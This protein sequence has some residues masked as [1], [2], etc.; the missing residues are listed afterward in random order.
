VA[1]SI[2]TNAQ[3]R[4]WRQ[5]GSLA[6]A[7]V[8]AGWAVILAVILSHRVFVTNDSLSNYIHVWYVADTFWGGHG[9][10]LHMPVAGHGQAYAFPYAFVPWMSASL[11]RPIF[12][13][14]IVTLW[15]V[16]GFIGVVV[17]Q[18]WAFPELRGGWWT[19][20][21][22]MNPMLVEAPVLG[23]QPFLWSAAMLFAAIGLWRRNRIVAAAIVLGLAQATHP[24]VMLPIAGP[25]VV[26]RLYRE[27][28]K[29][30][31]LIAYAASLVIALPA[32]LLVL[33]S[34][35]VG[36]ASTG[37]LLG[38]FAGTT[39]LRAVVIGGPFIAFAL[40]R[41][42]LSRVPAALFAFLLALNVVLVPIRHNQ[43]AWGA[44]TRSPEHTVDAFTKTAA[45][46]RGAMYRVL[47]AS[48]GKV[49]MYQMLQAGGRLDSEPFPESI[50]REG[51]ASLDAYRT[52]LA[53][54]KVK[55]VLIS[56][57]YDRHYATNEH[58][59]LEKLTEERSP[60]AVC[61]RLMVR[62]PLYD[63]YRIARDGCVT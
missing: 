55:Y 33:V 7:I 26:A 57:A 23:Q 18:W 15:L 12:G 28:H 3:P 5:P 59:L 2:L 1:R 38:N 45:F 47:D 39:S 41:T 63:L 22:L 50:H 32:T 58:T 61:A 53:D 40:L 30:R 4:A 56:M 19:A 34:P 8:L 42:P 54:R 29:T 60:A 27:P 21:L 14:W 17:A 11:L 48:D 31:L 37:V 44:L 20:L 10:P 24:A 25:I 43:F 9:V 49:S 52:F 13:D 16:L 35:T 62:D 6:L 51:F 36:D 46:E